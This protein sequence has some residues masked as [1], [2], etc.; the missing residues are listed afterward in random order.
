M[1][2]IIFGI[3]VSVLNVILKNGQPSQSSLLNPKRFETGDPKVE[4]TIVICS[5]LFSEILVSMLNVISKNG[6][7]SQSSLPPVEPQTFRDW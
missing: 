2:K 1:L 6:Q 4:V 7:P 3:L 5:K